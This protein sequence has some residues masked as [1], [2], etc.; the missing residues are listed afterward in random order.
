MRNTVNSTRLRRLS[1]LLAAL[2]LWMAAAAWADDL[3]TDLGGGFVGAAPS[4]QGQELQVDMQTADCVIGYIDPGARVY[5]P[6]LTTDWAMISI[7]QLVF[8]SVVDLDESLRPVP[9][10]ADNW[11]QDGKNWTFNLRRGIQF[12][13]GYELTA[14]DVVR[15]YQTL[16][17][18]GESN[19]YYERLQ[20]IES[21]EASQSDIYTLLVTAKN[22][23]MMTLY[24]MVFPVV[25]YETLYDDLPRGTGPYWY[26]QF[27][28]EGTVRLE[29]NPLWWKQQPQVKS[30]LLKR[31]DTSGDAIEA[32][33]THQ[34]DMLST[35]SPRASLS[36]R[37]SDMTS[38]D[39][40]TLTYEMLI[41]NLGEGRLTADVSVRQAIMFAI[42][43]SVVASNGYLDMAIQ[44]EVPILPTCWLYES[45]SA[46][47][48]YSPERALQ[49]MHNLGWYDL[50]GDGTL[51]KHIGVMVKEPDL[52]IVTY[53]ESTNSIRE[54]AACLIEEYLEAVG[55]NVTVSVL[56]KEKARQAIRDREYD[57]ALVGMNLS[58]VPYLTS[59]LKSGGSLNLNHYS[60]EDMDL[61]LDRIGSASDETVLRMV[62]SDIQKTIVE[63][64]PILGLLF[65]T[66]TV[67]ST[68]PVGGMGGLRAY[69]NF[70][71]FEFLAN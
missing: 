8:E 59:L 47:Y 60:N 9:M 38:I 46:I 63:R 37:L 54:N 21:M 4:Q 20:A 24:A 19:P 34:I 27:D 42:D 13:N 69:D 1:V 31:Y 29:A 68:R 49:L 28:E 11:V 18:S 50:N 10:L 51:N 5:S 53:N 30:I 40:A 16:L 66:G 23:S 39:Y 45:Q 32:I 48:Y 71:G 25:Q 65:R 52:T 64:L 35:K 3:A 22:T 17:Q 12:H 44:C 56:S 62:Y 58:E 6:L 15:S 61:L 55:F 33:R 2:W 57:L 14:Y 43:R 67:L 36:R 41:P 26:I 70:N 7:N